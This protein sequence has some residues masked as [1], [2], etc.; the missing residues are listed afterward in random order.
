MNAPETESLGEKAWHAIDKKELL[1]T[2]NTPDEGLS[3]EEA[4]A[5]LEKYGENRLP[6]RKAP[7]L[8]VVF[9]RQFKNPLIY[10]LLAA[11][12][13][14]V[15]LNEFTDAIFIA[16][17]LLLNASL[18]TFQEWGA[19]KNA[20]ALQEMLE[21]TAHVKRSGKKDSIPTREVVPGDMV[22]IESGEKVPAD[23]RLIET[24][25][26]TIDES[27]L[28]G[29]NIPPNK[30]TEVLD[31]DTPVADRK[32]MAFAGSVVMSGRGVGVAAATALETQAGKI[33]ENVSSSEAAKPPLILRME[34]FARQIS[35]LVGFGVV[36][37][38]MV[39][40]ARGETLVEI[41]FLSVALAVSSIPEGLPIA[42]TVALSVAVTRMARRKVIVRKLAAVEGL[43]SCTCIASDK[44]GTLTVNRQTVKSLQLFGV[45]RISVGGEGLE[46]EGEITR[47]DRELEKPEREH[48]ERLARAGALANEGSLSRNDDGK[49][50]AQGDAMDVALLVFADKTKLDSSA[51]RGEIEEL[52]EIPYESERKYAAK[53]YRREGSARVAVKGALETV[54]NFC[55]GVSAP[56]GDIEIDEKE[57]N[58]QVL[59]M[60]SEGFRV[61]AVAEGELDE[62]P[63]GAPEEDDIPKLKLLGL[64]GFLDPLRPEVKDSVKKC[65]EA[66]I[67][68]IMITGDHPETAFAIARDLGIVDSKDKVVNGERLEKLEDGTDE[69]REVITSATVFARVSPMQKLDIVEELVESGEFVAVTGDGV[70][71]APA[72]KKAH[73]GIAMG[74]GTDVA[75]DTAPI[76]V[77]DDNFASITAGVEEGRYAYDNLRKVTYL[78]ISTGFAEVVMFISTIVAGL[79]IPLTALQLLWL[80]VVTNGI[81]DVALAFEGGEPGAMKR[82]PRKPTEGI[83]NSLMI[84]Q[85]LISGTVMAIL[86]FTTWCCLSDRLVDKENARN[87]VLMLLVLCQN[88]HVFNA[89]SEH[90][91]A[92]K[93]PISRNYFVVIGVVLAQ[94]AH[95]LSMYLPFMQKILGVKPISLEYWFMLL[96]M[97]LVMLVV[98]EIYKFVRARVVDE[99]A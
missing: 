18:G 86:G 63:E 84:Q 47:P 27:F 2:L 76:V 48:I 4:A 39:G 3:K 50:E 21:T 71:D 36:I 79:S 33:A 25:N 45:G 29:E 16:I 53:F 52:G 98:M 38:A 91:S 11:L 43:G 17:V 10:V 1:E 34:K 32:N 30:N 31:E 24:K 62:V 65:R 42:M 73:I 72:L 90:T 83:F 51:I 49:M 58:D 82:K 96:G 88:V 57:I 13:V 54:L 93:T 12:V 55:D 87:I 40:L 89:R 97:A 37:V 19:E 20:A 22:L 78:L 59:D 95:I 46:P 14:T 92:F 77:T 6:S 74:S 66:G 9:L 68:V 81:Q 23:V 67:K 94:G 7:S 61:L 70:N 35:M 56:D 80:N 85:T 15:A 99:K 69:K 75:K 44:T 64:A 8:P 41:F 26:L 5:R 60:A 28:T